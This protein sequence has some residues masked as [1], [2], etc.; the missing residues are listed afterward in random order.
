MVQDANATDETNIKIRFN[1]LCRQFEKN[2]KY[3]P[4]TFESQT[5]PDNENI[6]YEMIV[7]KKRYEA[8]FYQIS[9]TM[10][11][12]KIREEIRNRLLERYTEEQL[13][14]PTEEILADSNHEA[15]MYLY[16]LCYKRS[17]WFMIDEQYGKYSI[18]LFYDNEFN[19][20]D[21]EDL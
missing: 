10:D 16:E 1:N 19:H 20:P 17:V 6:S 7:N 14:N 8:V 12:L 3:L 11:T 15:T 18:V 4:A 5:I 21:G 2:K 9:S 13:K